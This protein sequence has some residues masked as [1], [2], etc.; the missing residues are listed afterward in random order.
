[1]VEKENSLNSTKYNYVLIIIFYISLK[2]EFKK[3]CCLGQNWSFCRGQSDDAFPARS[4]CVKWHT[5]WTVCHVTRA[6]S[7]SGVQH[8]GILVKQLFALHSFSIAQASYLDAVS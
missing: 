8:I 4:E 7:I 5:A 3:N 6:K 1:M 2:T